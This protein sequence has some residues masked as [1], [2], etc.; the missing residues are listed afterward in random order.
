MSWIIICTVVWDLQAYEHKPSTMPAGWRDLSRSKW[1]LAKGD[2]QLDAT[3]A[4]SAH[5]VSDEA[6][7]ELAAC[8]YKA[9]FPAV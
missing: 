3:F 2:E 1:R 9:G 7:S 6:L 8:L 4:N 5:H